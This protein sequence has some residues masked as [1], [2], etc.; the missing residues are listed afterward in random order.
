M[1]NIEILPWQLMLNISNNE[2]HRLKLIRFSNERQ[3]GNFFGA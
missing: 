2:R 1:V 3:N